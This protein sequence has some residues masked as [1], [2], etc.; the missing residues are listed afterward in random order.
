MS[1]QPRTRT[2][3]MMVRGM[4]PGPERDAWVLDIRAIESEARKNPPSLR[5]RLRR[6][7]RV[8]KASP[9]LIVR[10]ETRLGEQ[11]PKGFYDNP[12]EEGNDR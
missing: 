8:L 10:R 2:G 7:W 4:K 9:P 11:R 1:N 12:D 5:K 6:W 3:Q